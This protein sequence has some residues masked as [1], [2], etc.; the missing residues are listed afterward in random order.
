MSAKT[1]YIEP[2]P[3]RRVSNKGTHTS[4]A[5]LIGPCKDVWVLDKRPK[6][7]VAT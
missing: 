6:Y 1:R 5:I 3:I 4:G 2:N 7:F